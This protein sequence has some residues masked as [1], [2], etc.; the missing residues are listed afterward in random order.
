MAEIE[1]LQCALSRHLKTKKTPEKWSVLLELLRAIAGDRVFATTAFDA[2]PRTAEAYKSLLIQLDIIGIHPKLRGERKKP[3]Q[4]V[5]SNIEIA[6]EI[7]A[8]RIIKVKPEKRV[9]QTTKNNDW[10]SANSDAFLSSYEWR[11]LRLVV[12]KKYGSR[13]QCCGANSTQAMICVDHIKPRKFFPELALSESNLQV[14]CEPCN[15]GKGNWDM[16]DFREPDVA[17]ITKNGTTQRK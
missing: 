17:E 12:L 13:C 4:I 6:A 10:K 3:K 2:P 5:R 1:K 15:H 7:T 9:K 16:T 14:L 8:S 11:K